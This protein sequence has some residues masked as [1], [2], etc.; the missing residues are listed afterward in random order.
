MIQRTRSCSAGGDEWGDVV[1]A[2]CP[3]ST[4][5][6]SNGK[7]AESGGE[8]VGVV[9]LHFADGAV[10]AASHHGVW[11]QRLRVR[12]VGPCDAVAGA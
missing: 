9:R 6:P 12:D 11:R 5:V 3:P 10:C 8:R 7:S 2:E 4:A 1:S